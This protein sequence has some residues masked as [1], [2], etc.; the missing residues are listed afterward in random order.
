[1]DLCE[2]GEEARQDEAGPEGKDARQHA[3]VL[4]QGGS[5]RPFENGKHASTL[6]SR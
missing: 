3:G 2:D 6:I 4:R 5:D 1:M